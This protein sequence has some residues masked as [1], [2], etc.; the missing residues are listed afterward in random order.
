MTAA[1]EPEKEA[2][3]YEHRKTSGKREADLSKLPVET[4]TYTLAEHQQICDCG[5]DSLHE[6]TT[7]T[8]REVAVVV[9]QVK[10]VE[11]VWQ[12]SRSS[13][14]SG[15]TATIITKFITSTMAGVSISFTMTG[16][17]LPWSKVPST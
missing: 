9:P 5:G 3:T 1:P 8:R 4:V 16:P 15:R 11:H 12:G 7:E 17:K 2:I 6:M 10:L 13:S 14:A